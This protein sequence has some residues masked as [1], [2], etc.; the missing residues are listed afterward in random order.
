MQHSELTLN[1]NEQVPIVP[2]TSAPATAVVASEGQLAIG[3]FMVLA[4]VA[5]ISVGLGRVLTTLYALHLGASNAQIGYIAAFET[6]GKFIVTLPAGFIIA[7]YG[8]QR[9]Y[10]LA[11]LFPMLITCVIPWTAVWW[12]V[13]IA[14]GLISLAIP[15]RIVSMNGSFLQQLKYL[16]SAKAGWYRGSQ[17]FGT[18]ILGPFIA[19]LVSAH[20]SFLWGFMLIALLFALMSLFGSNVLPGEGDSSA[21]EEAFGKDEHPV[22]RMLLQVCELWRVREVRDSCTMEFVN[23]AAQQVF[24]TFILVLALTV[25]KLPQPLAITL[26]TIQGITTVLAS[27]GLGHLLNLF[28]SNRLQWLSVALSIAGLALLGTTLNYPLLLLGTVLLCAGSALIGLSRT[29]RLSNLAGNK[30]KISGVYNLSSMGGAFVGAIGG[31][32]LSELLGLQGL[33]LAWIPIF[34]LTTCWVARPKQ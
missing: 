13:A 17:S 22:K 3:N 26:I 6:F 10:F 25:A 33:F 21:A 27:F 5:G 28:S 1:S 4:V 11:S 15:F 2:M 7:R 29:L 16:G 30:S 32:L 8:A 14:R 18:L 19:T 12:G 20:V 34:V 24:T 31:G 23:S 9:V